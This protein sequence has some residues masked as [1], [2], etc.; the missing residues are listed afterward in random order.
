VSNFAAYWLVDVTGFRGFMSKMTPGPAWIKAGALCLF[1][2]VDIALLI[3]PMFLFLWIVNPDDAAIL[4]GIFG[5][6]LGRQ[7][8]IGIVSVLLV[9]FPILIVAMKYEHEQWLKWGN[10]HIDD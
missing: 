5:G 6:E 1:M 8:A 4:I 10:L 3:A 7:L 9:L 2:C